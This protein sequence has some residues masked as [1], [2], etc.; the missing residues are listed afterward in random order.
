MPNRVLLEICVASVDD[1]V[2]AVAHG[3]DRLEVNS[4]LSL[5][6]LTPSAGLFAEVRR[7]V[8]VP[9]IAMVR[10]RSG[11]FCYSA[12]DF[13]VMRRDA[14]ALLHAGADGIAFGILTADG[15]VDRNRCRQLRDSC[16]DRDA[17]FHRAF[18]VTPDPFAALDALID[19]GFT[20]VL[21]SGRAESALRGADRLVGL[22]YRATGRIEILPASGI[23]ST[24]AAELVRRAGCDQVH[25]S[26]RT[27][28]TDPSGRARPLIQF[29]NGRLAEDQYERTDPAAVAALR[30][31]LDR[32]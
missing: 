27:V 14:E 5:G 2:A 10:P 24:I 26:A 7:R 25:A 30:A 1:A 3:A 31:A 17:V 29:G 22:R 28:A 20:R 13:Q 15:E 19:L 4:A 12:N 21:T 16:G 18:D 32:C 8:T 6:G 11:G 9:L 23:N